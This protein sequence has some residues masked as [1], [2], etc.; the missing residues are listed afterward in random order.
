MD[1]SPILNFMNESTR[2]ALHDDDAVE[3]SLR[4]Y[5]PLWFASYFFTQT[6]HVLTSLTIIPVI[7]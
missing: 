4:F 3:C 5:I 7:K 2:T 6:T 1:T